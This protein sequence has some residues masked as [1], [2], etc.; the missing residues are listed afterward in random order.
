MS[1]KALPHLDQRV[2]ALFFPV[3]LCGMWRSTRLSTVPPWNSLFVPDLLRVS[4]S[5][6]Q[7]AKRM[8]DLPVFF[9]FLCLFLQF[10]LSVNL[11]NGN[12]GSFSNSLKNGRDFFFCFA[13]SLLSSKR[14]PKGL[15]RES[16]GLFE[17]EK[18]WGQGGTSKKDTYGT[19]LKH[20]GR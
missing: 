8:I 11:K 3:W 7:V 1:S 2:Q 9:F 6:S 13:P 16:A 5:T 10:L 4:S 18:A 14:G 20:F 17:D 12:L 19:A 15:K